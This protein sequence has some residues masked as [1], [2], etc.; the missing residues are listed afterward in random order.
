VVSDYEDIRRELTPTADDVAAAGIRLDRIPAVVGDQAATPGYR[1]RRRPRLSSE[2]WE[3]MRV[4]FVKH[5]YRV[6]L[7]PAV[8]ARLEE[9]LLA[10]DR[11]L[12]LKAFESVLRDVLA[13]TQPPRES[14]GPIVPIQ[15]VNHI[16][17][18]KTDE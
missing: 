1:A 3:E 2:S 17:S 13:H 4:L 14:T 18:P 6:L 16:P 15:I 11:K 9:H 7:K 8:L 10:E 5:L 12:S